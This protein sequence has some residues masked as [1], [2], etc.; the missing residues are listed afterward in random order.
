MSE[1][2]VLGSLARS[3]QSI[4]RGHPNRASRRR[5]VTPNFA[6]PQL[7]FSELDRLVA[8]YGHPVHPSPLSVIVIQGVVLH[9][10]VVPHRDGPYLPF[11]S[12]G[13]TFFFAVVV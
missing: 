12:A 13:E 1:L 5:V 6:D 8:L 10:A 9:N 3:D 4:Y 11:D 2:D 7:W